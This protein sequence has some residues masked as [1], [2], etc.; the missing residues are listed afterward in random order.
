MT[1][2]KTT[3]LSEFGEAA[4]ALDKE[5]LQME[6]LARELERL[7]NPS[8]KG[9][10]RAETLLAE[11]DVCRQK[12]AANMQTM[13]KALDFVRQR[14]E[15]AETLIAERAA[16]VQER[17][18]E[19]ESQLQRYRLLAEM[20]GQITAAIMPFQR[21]KGGNLSDDDRDALNSHL[22][23]INEQLGLLVE[24]SNKLMN[25]ARKAQLKVLERNTDSLRQ[26]LQVIRLRL[27]SLADVA[28]PSGRERSSP[29][30]GSFEERI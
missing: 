29:Q 3:V 15:S 23:Q 12:M 13:A 19:A 9:L 2:Q 17:R 25:D 18:L 20:V 16:M 5:F 1:K 21:L 11:V 6:R 22:P 28:N 7:S 30:D 24:E 4:L 26:S 10:E 8:D 27:S 14:A